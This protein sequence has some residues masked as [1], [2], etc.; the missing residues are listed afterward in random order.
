MLHDRMI[1]ETYLF[2]LWA[3]R[4]AAAQK[5]L[6]AADELGVDRQD[7]RNV[8]STSFGF[9]ASQAVYDASGPWAPCPPTPPPPPSG[10]S[11]DTKPATT[12]RTAAK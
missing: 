10:P 1:N 11:D 6:Q 5:L 3:D 4:P 7:P 9:G 2:V 12:R 8:A